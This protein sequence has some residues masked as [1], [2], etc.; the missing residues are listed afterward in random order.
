MAK[1]LR[2]FLEQL[3]SASSEDFVEIERPISRDLYMT[4]I[5]EK[6]ARQHRYP[7][8]LF[9]HVTGYDWPVVTGMFS[10]YRLLAHALGIDP[11]R[12]DLALAEYMKRETN[13][14][15]PVPFCRGTAPVQEVVYTG[16]KVDLT[17]LPIQQHNPDDSGR[18][19]TI[20]C[21]IC[22][23][24]VSG[25]TNVGTYRHELKG[26]NRLGCMMNPVQHAETIR[27][28][29]QGA[30]KPM[31]VAIFV[32]HHP[33]YHI[34]AASRGQL[35]HDELAVTGGLLGEAVE[36]VPCKTVDMAVPAYAEVVIEGR[37]QPGNFEMD[38]P[39]GEYAGYYGDGK[40][41]P[42]IDVTAITHRKQPIWHD[43]YPSFREHTQV[44]V[45]AREAQLFRRVREICPTLIGV[46]LPASGANWWHCYV[47][48]KKRVQGEGKLAGLV[49]LGSHYDVKH[50]VVVDDDIDIYNDEAVLWAIATRLQA[51]RDCS[52]I[53]N[54]FGAHLDPSA[55][56]EIR[57]EHGPMTTKVIFDT[58]RPLNSKFPERVTPSKK[59]WDD[60]D[61]REYVPGL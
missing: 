56:G 54:S 10:S 13:L 36:L 25:V 7:A 44:G 37:I 45:L 23:D 22:K 15:A 21:L 46:H 14:I 39:F 61:L 27:S 41:V 53:T 16:N 31:E 30:G 28:R 59:V 29:Y 2:S 35:E 3:R 49:V 8:V 17:K 11:T 33:A 26:P 58:T 38:G 57:H 43:L 9:K 32:G 19:I 42:I 24:P 20:G 55:Y 18:Y 4:A 50:V 60:I 1:D 34:G 47:S 6:L 51:D 52:Y 40:N 5:Q 48:L 12:K